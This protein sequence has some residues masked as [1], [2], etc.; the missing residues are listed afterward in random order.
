MGDFEY[1]G[2]TAKDYKSQMVTVD[3]EITTTPRQ[4]NDLFLML[5]CDGI[6]DC[7]TSEDGGEQMREAIKSKP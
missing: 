5:A 2:N 6:W 1:K 7:V 4:Q 3:P